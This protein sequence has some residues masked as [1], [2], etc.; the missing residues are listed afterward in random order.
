MKII[1]DSVAKFGYY[2]GVV[3]KIAITHSDGDE[4][5]SKLTKTQREMLNAI[6]RR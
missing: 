6:T 1:L 2:W 5:M 4:K 3:S